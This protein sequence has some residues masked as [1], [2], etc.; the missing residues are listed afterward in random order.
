MPVIDKTHSIQAIN[1]DDQLA[2]CE[3]PEKPS[4]SVLV[5]SVYLIGCAGV[6]H[7]PHWF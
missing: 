4:E 3:S 5:V 6:V 2:F 1:D 7:A